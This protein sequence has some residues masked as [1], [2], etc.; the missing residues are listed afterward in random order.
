MEK[1]VFNHLWSVV[2]KRLMIGYCS[3]QITPWRLITTK[4]WL[5]YPLAYMSWSTYYTTFPVGCSVILN[6]P[7]LLS[8]KKASQKRAISVYELVEE[9]DV[10][11]VNVLSALNTV[12]D[13]ILNHISTIFW[14]HCCS[15]CQSKGSFRNRQSEVFWQVRVREIYKKILK[16]YL[17]SNPLLSK[18]KG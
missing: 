1:S 9:L 13:I 5:V 12:T 4:S 2:T 8:A 7:W 16:T 15:K 17:C 3:M 11:V 18:A 10:E 6:K 14:C